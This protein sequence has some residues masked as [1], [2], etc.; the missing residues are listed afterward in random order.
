V[1]ALSGLSWIGF[2]AC[3]RALAGAPT[4]LTRGLT[5]MGVTAAS[6]LLAVALYDR[7]AAREDVSEREKA[8]AGAIILIVLFS[9]ILLL[10]A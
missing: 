7:M 8:I 9:A 3:M 6:V 10:I 1:L 4:D 5:G 2:F